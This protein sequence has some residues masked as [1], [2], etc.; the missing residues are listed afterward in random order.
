MRTP[1]SE[2]TTE[3]RPTVN[4]RSVSVPG[5]RAR[6]ELAQAGAQEAE[7]EQVARAVA[8]AGE[9]HHRRPAADGDGAE[10][11]QRLADRA[12]AMAAAEE[13]RVGELDQLQRQ[14]RVLGDHALE[15][16]ERGRVARGEHRQRAEAV[17][18]DGG[19]ADDDRLREVLALEGV[20]AEPAAD[21]VL[22][23]RLHA[24]GDQLQAEPARDVDRRLDLVLVQRG[25]V[26]LDAVGE[27][28]QR[29][30][31]GVGAEVVEGDPEARP[32]APRAARRAAC[33]RRAGRR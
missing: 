14:A 13:R 25:D 5:V 23:A 6:D 7:L 10:R 9:D 20:E 2:S 30:G 31:A 4:A 19:A 1:S 3:K 18:R 24:A 21:A 28:E 11:H 33:R 26:E 27:L 12:G 32:R 29:V 17:G 22:L 16:L 8:D 15:L